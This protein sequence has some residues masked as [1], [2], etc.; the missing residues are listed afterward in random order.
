[1][2]ISGTDHI[3][4][5][6]GDRT[7]LEQVFVNLLANAVKYTPV[8]GS[9]SVSLGID[10]GMAVVRIT[11]SGIGIEPDDLDRIFEAFTRGRLSKGE[12]GLGIGLTVAR[13]LMELH[14]GSIGAASAGR[15]CGSEFTLSL[16]AVVGGE[17]SVDS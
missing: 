6:H 3:V 8:D 1:M 12:R 5:V 16:P 9:V 4:N 10:D 7:R 14:G 15:G 17:T 2:S 13:R 11:D